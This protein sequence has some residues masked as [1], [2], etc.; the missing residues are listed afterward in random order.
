[1]FELAGKKVK[2]VLFAQTPHI[3]G[4]GELGRSLPRSNKMDK[5]EMFY[6]GNNLYLIFNG[7]KTKASI[8]AANLVAVEYAE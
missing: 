7:G 1:M 8:P 5:L 6:D 4:V 3:P 2:Y